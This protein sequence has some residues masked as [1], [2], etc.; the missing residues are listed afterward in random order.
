VKAA[1]TAPPH[2]ALDAAVAQ[3]FAGA[4]MPGPPTIGI[5]LELIPFRL[6]DCGVVPMVETRG[7]LRDVPHVSFE[8]TVEICAAH[9]PHDLWD[10][11][12]G[13][14]MAVRE[15]RR[16]AIQLLDIAR[17][18]TGILPAGYLPAD[19]L[20]LFTHLARRVDRSG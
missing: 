20:A 16:L 18:A 15:M 3:L 11:A 17:V 2:G 19:T 1:V 9:D 13:A 4:S 7:A 5:E 6:R 12:A 8:P 10:H 14:G